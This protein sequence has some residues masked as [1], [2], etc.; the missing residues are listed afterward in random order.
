M[1]GRSFLAL[2]LF[3]LVLLHGFGCVRNLP[4]ENSKTISLSVPN[5][6]GG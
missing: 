3:G 1:K 2:F 5:L 6:M 4:P